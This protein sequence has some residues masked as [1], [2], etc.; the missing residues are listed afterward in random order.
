MNLFVL[1]LAFFCSISVRTAEVPKAQPN[2]VYSRKSNLPVPRNVRGPS[3]LGV[4]I[5]MAKNAVRM[6]SIAAYMG[7]TWYLWN[8]ASQEEILAE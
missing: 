3:A 4:M 8:L 2:T 7:L 5:K 6:A 1:F